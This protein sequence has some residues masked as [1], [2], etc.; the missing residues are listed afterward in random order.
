MRAEAKAGK[1]GHVQM[2]GDL[3]IASMIA[4]LRHARGARSAPVADRS[5]EGACG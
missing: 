1:I 4:V 2:G 5:A 3:A